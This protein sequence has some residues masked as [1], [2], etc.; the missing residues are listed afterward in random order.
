MANSQ[1]EANKVLRV[2]EGKTL[3]FTVR[4]HRKSGQVIEFQTDHV[5][6]I[7]YDNETRRNW[8][9]SKV[10]GDDSSYPEAYPVCPWEEGDILLTEANP[11]P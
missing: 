7:V 2:I 1:S 11:K 3:K 4:I 9:K 6:D 10:K 5:P 8:I